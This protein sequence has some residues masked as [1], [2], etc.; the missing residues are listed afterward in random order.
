MNFRMF[1]RI[2]SGKDTRPGKAAP[3]N[4]IGEF[5]PVSDAYFEEGEIDGLLSMLQGSSYAHA[6]TVHLETSEGELIFEPYEDGIKIR[7]EEEQ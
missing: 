2:I 3:A 6:E 4:T 5:T 7:L 1:K